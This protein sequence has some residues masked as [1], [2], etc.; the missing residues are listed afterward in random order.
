MSPRAASGGLASPEDFLVIGS[1]VAGLRAAVGLSQ[2]GRVVILTKG[3]PAEGSSIYAQGGVAVAPEEDDIAV[4]RE[5]TLRAGNGLCREEA[6]QILVEE[7]PARIQELIEWGAR[8][9][10]VKGEYALARESAHSRSRILR[11]GGDATGTEMV[12]ALLKRAR[13]LRQIVWREHHFTTNLIL[14][15]DGRCAGAAVMDET[16]GVLSAVPARAVVLSTGGAGQIYART[17]NPPSA[18]GDGIAMAYRAGAVLEDMEFVQFHPTAL[19]MPNTPPFLLSEAMRGEGGIL[20]NITGEAFMKRYHEMA[21]A[22][23][24]DIVSR[25]IWK[26][27]IATRTR[28]VYLDVTHLGSAFIRKRF[29]TIYATC[30][31]YDVDITEE[32]I[33]VSPSAHF[34]MGGVK[35]NVDGATSIPGLFAAG[36]V[37]CAGVH[38]A[39]RLASNSLLEGLVF[40][41][42][43][44]DAA[45]RDVSK[46][47]PLCLTVPLE[48]EG[49]KGVAHG[50]PDTVPDMDKLLNMLRRLMW[51]KVGIIRNREDLLVAMTRIRE[52]EE[53]LRDLC[54]TRRDWEIQNM[55][56]VGRL[57]ATAA[58][59]RD[60]SIGAHFRSDEPEGRPAGWDRHIQLSAG[61]SEDRSETVSLN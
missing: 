17:T 54:G 20:R 1:G 6:V 18:T 7:G 53:S 40:G 33:P 39:N 55:M 47:L 29:P 61:T 3:G 16:T 9:D 59:Q 35:T 11:A 48:S 42:R 10:K 34:M 2:I 23:P 50:G 12:R 27:M 60:H 19:Y 36:E 43:A 37:A 4:H 38:G 5:D 15:R 46:T 41:A 49:Q 52:W 45:A 8:F 13:S 31:R 26:E 51:E 32:M 57:V 30:L 22:A 14:D 25:A 28:H 58:F 21:E 44:A 24:R 56:T